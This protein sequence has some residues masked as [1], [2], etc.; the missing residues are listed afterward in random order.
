MSAS[1]GIALVAI[2]AS[3]AEYLL[4]DLPT[5]G[6]RVDLPPLHLAE[7]A[8]E[9]LVPPDGA[10]EMRLCPRARDRKDLAGEMLGTA[11][12]QEPFI[13]QVGAVL[14]DLFPQLGD[15]LA[16]HRVGQDDRR[17]PRAVRVE[18]ED[19]AHLVHHGLRG[20]VVALVHGDDVGNL[21]D[22]GLEGLDRVAGAGHEDEKN[23]V[24]D[25]DDLDFA[26]T[27]SDRLEEHELLP[28][29]VEQ[30][31]CLQGGLG[32]AS[33]V[34]ARPH[35]ADEDLRIE[36]M[37][38][39]TDPVAEQRAL[40]EG[41]RGIDGNHA[42]GRVPLA[43]IAK[44]RADEARLA[45]TRRAGDADD[46]RPPRLGVELADEV[47]GERV[48]ALDQRDRTRERATLPG[49]HAVEQPFERP[50]LRGQAAWRLGTTSV[51]ARSSE[52]PRRSAKPTTAA[53]AR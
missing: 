2:V 16:P 52:T 31:G 18:R 40:R 8:L 48:R 9:L 46:V 21:H 14:L 28:G 39:E 20:R 22:S 11:A 26:L 4:H 23:G 42:D 53:I 38:G 27:G 37:V 49:T 25:P 36:E 7:E 3:H 43:Y 45:D 47:V 1:V 10:L 50:S 24:C 12:L 15:A 44:Q 13:L 41:A 17:L 6:R 29:R 30:E 51:R 34:S 32:Q 33:Q 35:R 5:R 19:R